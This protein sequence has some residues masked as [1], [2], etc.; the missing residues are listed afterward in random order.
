LGKQSKTV[1]ETEKME[2]Y[3]YYC[4]VEFINETYSLWVDPS[5]NNNPKYYV[6]KVFLEKY[7][8][9]LAPQ[10]INCEKISEDY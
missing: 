6:S 9:N 10:S 1:N 3:S 8:K 5:Y 2:S 7:G 4:E